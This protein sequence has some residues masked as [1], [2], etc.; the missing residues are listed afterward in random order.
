M[1]LMESIRDAVIAE[2]FSWSR[3][4]LDAMM[5]TFPKSIKARLS[6]Q[7]FPPHSRRQW[8]CGNQSPILCNPSFTHKHIPVQLYI[9]NVRTRKNLLEA[10][11]P[12]QH[13]ILRG[14]GSDNSQTRFHHFT[15]IQDE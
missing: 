8:T 7:Y 4:V 5:R 11:A 6:Y 14:G 9:A 2:R 12:P 13:L 3:S 10:R 1:R 15:P